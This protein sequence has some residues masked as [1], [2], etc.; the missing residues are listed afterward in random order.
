M[1]NRDVKVLLKVLF[2]Y[3][4]SYTCYLCINVIYITS[5]SIL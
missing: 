2:L 3:F 5:Y 1:Q 4:F